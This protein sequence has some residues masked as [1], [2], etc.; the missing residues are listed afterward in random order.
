MVFGSVGSLREWVS[1]YL[2]GFFMGSADTIPGVSGG[3]I[4]LITGIYERLIAALTAVDPATLRDV[5]RPHDPESRK[6]VWDQL[7][8]MDLP[9]LLTLGAGML[10]AIVTLAHAL[11]TAVQQ[12]PGRAYPGTVYGIPFRIVSVDPGNEI[13]CAV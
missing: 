7:I 12:H 3:T 13:V 1:V 5:V 10:T 6:A 8:R 4:A 2:K 9:F 11:E